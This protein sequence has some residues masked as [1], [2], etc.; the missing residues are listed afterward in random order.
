MSDAQPPPIVPEHAAAAS[1]RSDLPPELTAAPHSAAAVAAASSSPSAGAGAAVSI[2]LS[3]GEEDKFPREWWI[4]EKDARKDESN[5]KEGTSDVWNV[6]FRLTPAYYQDNSL[7]PGQPGVA[8]HV[9]RASLTNDSFCNKVMELYR[10]K[11]EKEK[12][13]PYITTKAGSHLARFHEGTKAAAAH[14]LRAKTLAHQRQRTMLGAALPAKSSVQSTLGG[15]MSLSREQMALRAQ[16]MFF[17]YSKQHISKST[18]CD[19]FF[20]AMIRINDKAGEPPTPF[21]SY[22]MIDKWILAE[23]GI[24]KLFLRH[25]LAL[26]RKQAKGNAF[27]QGQHDGGTL[28][29]R[30]KFEV[31]AL[32]WV[33]PSFLRN[34]VIA[35]G[36]S[37]LADLRARQDDAARLVDE[38]S[39][40]LGQPLL[41][42]QPMLTAA[43]TGANVAAEFKHVVEEMTGQP[44][45]QIVATT[46]QDGA[47]GSVAGHLPLRLQEEEVCNMHL[48]AKI[49][50]A[51][52]G[53]LVRTRMKVAI[54]AFPDGQQLCA[55]VLGVAKRFSWS[56][57]REELAH[58]ASSIPNVSTGR[59]PAPRTCPQTPQ[60]AMCLRARVS[61]R[62]SM[63]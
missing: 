19:P 33:D 2:D 5:R 1:A 34:N 26:K 60:S 12:L 39:D 23:F 40:C 13:G 53:E 9:C 8:T 15:K 56:K 28:A 4:C 16:M 6:V 22:Q 58:I 17:I 42:Q 57:A 51:A 50:G 43:H 38:E 11:G 63:G 20:H 46:I 49:S 32:Q 59:T 44:F 55:R 10:I 30:L 25:A 7:T 35:I 47:A 27:A 62:A 48:G 54:D 24:F 61:V 36:L 41:G 29:N 37:T 3:Q 14:A 31:F 52:I 45:M 18:L 21:I